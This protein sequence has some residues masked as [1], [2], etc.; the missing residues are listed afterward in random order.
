[1][2]VS[3][4]VPTWNAAGFVARILEALVRQEGVEYEV[5]IVDNGVVNRET[6]EVVAAWKPKFP[7]L[8]YL[9]FARQLG[10]AGAVNAG[11]RAA[12]YPLVAVTNNDNIPAPTWLAELLAEYQRARLE[13]KEAIVTGLVD[14]PDFPNPLGARSNAYGRVVRASSEGLYRPFHPDGSCFLF[15]KEVFGLPYDEDYFIY[16]ED[17]YLGWRAWLGG[18]EVRL[19]EKSRAVTFDGGSTRRIAYR[20]AYYTER[21]RWLNYFLFFSWST[22]LRLMPLLFLDAALKF[23][24][25]SNRR[26]KA[27]A[28]WWL[29]THPLPVLAKRARIQET[30]RRPDREI[31]PLLSRT[32][33]NPQEKGARVLNA[34]FSAAARALCL[35]LGR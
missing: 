17:V 14:R 7:G 28:W 16:Q 10:Y 32:Y 9:S 30:R 26:A 21:N 31:L 35:R 18:Q 24:A 15:S 25:G 6:E 8:V 20:T 3:V 19:A 1:M 34:F 11:V 27:H 5:L 29:A 22:I 12:S 4:V 13:G 23:L 2:K 33:A